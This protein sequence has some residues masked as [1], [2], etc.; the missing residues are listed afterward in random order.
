MTA[1]ERAEA[2]HKILRSFD[3]W[4]PLTPDDIKATCLVV[5]V[6][7]YKL[8][9]ASKCLAT[10]IAADIANHALPLLLEGLPEEGGEK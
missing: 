5:I 8:A 3:D 2:A 9:G 1:D 6:C 10:T 4:S 7:A